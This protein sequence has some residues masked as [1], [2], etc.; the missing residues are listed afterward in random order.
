MEDQS[1]ETQKWSY[2]LVP[3]AAELS[4]PTWIDIKL[5]SNESD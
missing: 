2:N 1:Q 5:A 4:L 3:G